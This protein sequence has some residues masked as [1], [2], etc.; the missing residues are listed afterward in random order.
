MAAP[1]REQVGADVELLRGFEDGYAMT[2]GSKHQR[3]EIMYEK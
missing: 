2:V 3:P 1:L